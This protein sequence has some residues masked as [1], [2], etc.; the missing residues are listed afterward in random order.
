MNRTIVVRGDD[1][2]MVRVRHGPSI[3]FLLP[4]EYVDARPFFPP[5]SF[6]SPFTERFICRSLIRDQRAT[7]GK[8]ERFISSLFRAYRTP[9][10]PPITSDCIWCIIIR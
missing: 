1:G 8:L 4:P 2:F 5:S 3:A 10:A 7:A 6:S 9:S